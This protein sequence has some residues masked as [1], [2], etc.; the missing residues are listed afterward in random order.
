MNHHTNETNQIITLIQQLKNNVEADQSLAY[1]TDKQYDTIVDEINGLT[2]VIYDHKI[3]SNQSKE[4]LEEINHI[5]TLISELDLSKEAYVSD[6]GNH[7]DH[8]AIGL[9]LL[10]HHLNRK[11]SPLLVLDQVFESTKDL[12][13]VT[14]ENGK[15]IYANP[16]TTIST[17]KLSKDIIGVHVNDFL[18]I[19]DYKILLDKTTTL[20]VNTTANVNFQTSFNV[21]KLKAHKYT[22]NNGYLFVG[23]TIDESTQ[24][25]PKFLDFNFNRIHHDV[26]GP[27]KSIHAVTDLGREL[28]NK[29]C[30]NDEELLWVFDTIDKCD[31]T[32][33]YHFADLLDILSL[34]SN[35]LA[36]ELI[37][38]QDIVDKV[39][40]Q[41]NHL[42][43]FGNTAIKVD[44]VDNINFY[45]K[46]K[47]IFSIIHNLLS[48][49][50]KY[51]KTEEGFESRV[52]LSIT[53]S[54][55]GI[56]IEIKDNGIGIK[57]EDLNE[58]FKPHFRATTQSQGKGLGLYILKE[59]ISNLEG[60]VEVVSVYEI[61]TAFYVQLPNLKKNQPQLYD[62]LTKYKTAF[63][64]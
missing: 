16:A 45:S 8:I 28:C 49:A 61:G 63:N 39:L 12:I 26:M 18:S 17:Q 36:V 24:L 35:D 13:L 20:K 60:T 25:S 43:Y 22:T 42:D 21:Q 29:L 47:I 27:I 5:M 7:L 23:R 34:K 50:I 48:N 53:N 2:E 52:F 57:K 58:I 38:F 32:I 62:E 54:N 40:A 9:N 10:A 46:R 19:P 55:D 14:D 3:V 6:K 64:L 56:N 31:Q 15:I 1:I 33:E 41:L 11:I 51:Q 4:R 44:I 59:I 37:D 30:N